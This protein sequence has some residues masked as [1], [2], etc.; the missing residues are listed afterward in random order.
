M[1]SEGGAGV[2]LESLWRD[3]LL[4]EYSYYCMPLDKVYSIF[5]KRY[6]L[7]LQALEITGKA[8]ILHGKQDAVQIKISFCRCDG[9]FRNLFLQLGRQSR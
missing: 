7:K 5:K 6:E 8:S 4:S 1:S 9:I 3:L 2:W